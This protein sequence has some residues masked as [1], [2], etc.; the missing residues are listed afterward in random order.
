MTL[1]VLSSYNSQLLSLL[2]TLAGVNGNIVKQYPQ[3]IH[4]SSLEKFRAS[5]KAALYVSIMSAL[6]HS[7]G[8]FS[9]STEMKLQKLGTGKGSATVFPYWK[10]LS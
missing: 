6:L 4:P 10:E 8:D 2:L 5:L 1:Q 9:G 7:R 3:F